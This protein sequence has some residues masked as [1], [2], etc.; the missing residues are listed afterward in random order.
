MIYY[1]SSLARSPDGG[2]AGA[3]RSN[4]V[5]SSCYD[6]YVYVYVYV[7]VCVCAYIYIYTTYAYMYIYTYIHTYM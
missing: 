2:E 7:Y 3:A 5:S 6:M 1:Y 4:G